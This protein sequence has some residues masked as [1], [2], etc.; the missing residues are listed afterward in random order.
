MARYR[1][2]RLR[3]IRRLGEL[4]G[5]TQKS[6]TRDFPPG[7]HGPKK[8]GGGNQKSKESQYAVRLKEKQKLRFN[9]GISERQ[10][11][12]YVRE[13][14]RRK[15][16]TGEILLQLLEM[17]LDNIVFRLGFAPTIAAARQLISHGHVVVNQH[18]VTIPSYICKLNDSIS[19]SSNSQKFVKNLIERST[20]QISAPHL[21]VNIEKL[22][23]VVVDTVP[24]DAVG[25]QINELLVVEYYSR[26][27]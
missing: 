3:I 14:R 11:I 25:L 24:R 16:S 26:K 9:Y 22:S 18:R 8:R 4:P 7:Q 19:V 12:S 6:C 1:G 17:R 23:A 27:V 21:E 2:P 15:G 20:S 13:A 5:L 10:L